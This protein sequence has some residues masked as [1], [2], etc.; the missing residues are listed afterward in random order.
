MAMIKSTTILQFLFR[1]PYGIHSPFLYDYASRCLFNK[2]KNPDFEV[3]EKIRKAYL[4]SGKKLTVKDYGQ[5]SRLDRA[6]G[7]PP[8]TAE[9]KLNRIASRSLQKPRYCR[10]L[11]HT[12]NFFQA[13]TILELGT[14][15]GISTAYLAKACPKA[16]VFTLEGC[17]EISKVALETF[18]KAGT[19]NVIQITGEFG[20]ELPG[21]LQQLGK[22]DL[23]YLDGNH[24]YN[25]VMDYFS[26]ISKHLH[27]RSV[28]IVDD[29]RWSKGMWKA[30]KALQE[31]PQKTLS[32][33]LGK[34]GI[35]F[36][37]PKLSRE[38][39]MIG[40]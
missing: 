15:L 8:F 19:P 27:S 4:K 22:A 21:L 5:G 14:S 12:A 18:K 26:L 39:L 25:P 6:G 7:K 34:L 31:V 2:E 17:P 40:F 36:F 30:W 3:I 35:L 11:Y 37:D 16:K 28:F 1:K 10:V 24:G 13:Q 32:I 23:V 33:D 29:I 38:N 9:K 20:R